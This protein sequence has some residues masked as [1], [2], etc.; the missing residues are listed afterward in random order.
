MT[1][2]VMTADWLDENGVRAVFDL[3]SAAGHQIYAVGGCVRNSLMGIDATDIDFAS[4]APPDTVMALAKSAGIKAVPTGVDHGTVTLVIAGVGYEVTTFRKDVETDG[5]RAVVA[6]ADDPHTDSLRR[7]FTMN[8]IYAD[9]NGRLLDPQNGVPDAKARRVRF[10]GEAHERI[11][12]DALRILRFFRFYAQFGDVNEGLDATG[13][14][15]CAEH[16]EL[17]EALSA[18]RITTEMQKLLGAAD[19]A[20]SLSAMAASGVLA[21][22]LPGADAQILPVLVHVEGA[23]APEWERRLVAMT[24]AQPK[25]VDRL[26]LSKT[27]AKRLDR[28]RAALDDLH[29]KPLVAGYLYGVKPAVDAALIRAAGLEM[30]LPDDTLDQIARG[31]TKNFPVS[32]RDLMPAF[33]PGPAL[34]NELKRLEKLWLGSDMTLTKS[35]LLEQR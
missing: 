29:S 32:A 12:E 15:A 20:P 4:D 26:R 25:A 28:T 17:I 3:L 13:L 2:E 27:A 5:R 18:E 6:F 7:D 11:I 10:I 21:R 19:P 35:E 23:L 1:D 22:S 8:A 30:P 9:A 34:G 16:A 14:A 33:D 31:A 24:L